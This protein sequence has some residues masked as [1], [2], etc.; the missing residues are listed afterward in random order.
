[1]PKSYKKHEK[2]EQNNQ[3]FGRLVCVSTSAHGLVGDKRRGSRHT[4]LL[5]NSDWVNFG[6]A[7]LN[8]EFSLDGVFSDCPGQQTASLCA[9]S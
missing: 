6:R 3:P 2:R 9:K 4:W 1:M 8:V 5:I 7:R